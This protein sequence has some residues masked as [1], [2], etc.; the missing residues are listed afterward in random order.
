MVFCSE[1]GQEVAAGS[2]VCAACGSSVQAVISPDPSKPMRP[3]KDILSPEKADSSFEVIWRRIIKSETLE[4]Q[5]LL[6]RNPGKV[7]QLEGT[8]DGDGVNYVDGQGVKE[9]LELIPQTSAKSKD[10]IVSLY[11]TLPFWSKHYQDIHEY[12]FSVDPD[13]VIADWKTL[14]RKD[15]MWGAQEWRHPPHGYSAPWNRSVSVR[16]REMNWRPVE[17]EMIFGLTL[18]LDKVEMDFLIEIMNHW[19]KKIRNII[20]KGLKSKTKS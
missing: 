9:F 5:D 6:K 7:F 13:R 20:Q 12:M 14:L 4:K 1:C 11:E 19:S 16:G 17:K 18:I 3:E 10:K 2:K 8:I 15:L